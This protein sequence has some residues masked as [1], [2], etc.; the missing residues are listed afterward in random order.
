MT[1][2]KTNQDAAAAEAVPVQKP[3]PNPPG[4]GRWKWDEAAE[5]WINLDPKPETPAQE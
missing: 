2:K 3:I 4:G 5:Q 1:T